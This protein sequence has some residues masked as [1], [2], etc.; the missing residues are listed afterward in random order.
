MRVSESPDGT[1]R[2]TTM[3]IRIAS[4]HAPFA[5][6]SDEPDNLPTTI[7]G[8]RSDRDLFGGWG[9]KV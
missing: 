4:K 5:R 3:K 8:P 7:A 2:T 9:P 6:R 1:S